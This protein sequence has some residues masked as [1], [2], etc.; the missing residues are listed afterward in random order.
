MKS[1]IYTFI[2]I[3]ILLYSS[4]ST[5]QNLQITGTVRDEKTALQGTSVTVKGTSTGV[6]TDAN[7]NFS[8]QTAK[9]NTLVFSTAGYIPQEVVVGDS[10]T[11]D[12]TLLPDVSS[13][14]G[15]VVIGYGTKKKQHLSGSVASV[16]SEVIESRPVLN[17]LSAIQGQIP[18][19]T[20]ERYSGQPGAEGFNLNVRGFSSVNGGNSPLVLIDGVAGHL[21]LLNPDDI[22]SLTVLKD[23]A[24]SIYG[25]RAAG[26]VI[27]VTTKKGRKGKMIVSY[28]NNFAVSKLA[29]MM[30]TP[31]LY[32][33]AVM[34]N[35]AN[36]HNGAV[37]MYSPDYLERIKRNDPTPVPHPLY[38]GWMLFFTNTD[39]REAVFTNGFQQ[40]HN[41]TVSG[42]GDNS[43][44]YL[45]GSFTD[46]DGVIK[47][48]NDNNKR[49]NL[50]MNYDYDFS[51]RVRLET[52]LALENQVRSDIGGVGAS[53]LVTEAIFGMPNHPVYTQSGTKY[54]AQGGWGNAVAMA[55]EA[56]TSTF[57]TQN[58][59]ANFKLI[60]DVLQGLKLNLQSGISYRTQNDR[61]IARSF[62]LYTWDESSIAYYSIAN[63][64]EANLFRRSAENVYRN[65]TGY[66]QYNKS[67]G[68][69]HDIDIMGGVSQEE[70]D[71]NW[72]SARR[73]NFPTDQVWSLNL[74]G[75]N[76]MSNDEGYNIVTDNE[77]WTEN[78][79]IRSLFSRIGYV[80]DNK[81][82]VEANLRYDGSS[83]LHP[84]TRWGLFPGVSFAWRLSRENF[85]KDVRLFNDLKLRASYGET[86]NQEFLSPFDYLQLI[87]IGGSYPF[88]AGSQAQS[89]QL[90]GMVSLDRSWE[91]LVN[92]NIG[93]DITLLSSKLNFSFDYFIKRNKDMSVNI[94]Y[95]MVLGAIPPSTNSGELKTWGFETS[96]QW[97]DRVSDF[98]YSARVILSDQKNELTN[99]GGQDTYWLGLVPTRQGFPVNTYFAYDFAGV[100]R[101]Q[102]ELDDY[103]KL[104]GVPNDI[105]LGD[106]MFRDINGDGKISIYSDVPGQDGDVI[107][108]GNTSPRY[109]FGVNLGAQFKNFDLGIFIQGVG[110]RT[111]F[112]EGEYS[113]PWSDWWRQPP[114]YYSGKTWNEDRPDA[115]FPKLSFGNIRY[116]NYEK[117]TLQK[118]NGAYARLKNLQIGYTIPERLIGKVFSKARIYFSGENLAEWHDVQGGWDPESDRW[119]FNYPFQRVYSAGIDITF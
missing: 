115:P 79:A 20:V 119:G 114:L 74:G 3:F 83:R 58:V 26:G 59:N 17:T 2:Y 89:A 77:T 56:A 87:N 80:Y 1:T 50:R 98:Q 88:G 68:G 85:M 67:L 45:S 66:L 38:G 6:T 93:I 47:Y 78:W 102:K 53:W 51:K 14:E 100:I 112:R 31:N 106:A 60:A 15:V 86:G 101:T 43:A 27:L 30:E 5:A 92:K 76:N 90:A 21:N 24:A 61:D 95:P 57:K 9:G 81:Y 18:G 19:V 7:G 42:S 11:L 28:N 73:D 4:R 37:P 103:K 23:A 65:F 54:F 113:I 91:T 105:G 33:F 97:K 16:G 108:V 62:P 116:W 13:L 110:K 96:I 39:W 10:T 71:Y 99:L 63:P 44:Y 82:I 32:E 109:T 118:I 84:D 40:K 117:S 94:T 55:K 12:I 29:G 41:I 25:A 104:G 70:N 48:G 64:N 69:K 111:L 107:N 72:F 52:K 75:T 22:E 8:I 35:E 34:E 36:I 46:Q 49:Y